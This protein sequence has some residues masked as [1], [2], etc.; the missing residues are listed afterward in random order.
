MLSPSLC[1]YSCSLTYVH[2]YHSI[3]LP[4]ACCCWS[5]LSRACQSKR[6]RV[7]AQQHSPHRAGR[8]L[9]FTMVTDIPGHSYTRS[10][11]PVRA[12]NYYLMQVN[13]PSYFCFESALHTIDCWTMCARRKQEPHRLKTPA[14]PTVY[15]TC[16]LW[17][18]RPSVVCIA[19]LFLF[20][21][22]RARK[23]LR[24]TSPSL[25]RVYSEKYSQPQGKQSECNP[26]DHAYAN[27]ITWS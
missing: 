11:G 5:V 27:T 19:V 23:L 12:A 6:A 8:V 26:T 16:R 10:S 17:V 4:A 24:C 15:L 13:S 7:R 3:S 14:N 25:V 9:H 20:W 18:V 2:Q 21:S 22:V 1:N